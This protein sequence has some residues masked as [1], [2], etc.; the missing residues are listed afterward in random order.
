MYRCQIGIGC[1]QA[2]P[3][4]WYFPISIFPID[5]SSRHMF[6]SCLLVGIVI[7]HTIFLLCKFLCT[8]SQNTLISNFSMG[9]HFYPPISFICGQITNLLLSCRHTRKQVAIF[10]VKLWLKL[11]M[12]LWCFYRHIKFWNLSVT[13]P[14]IKFCNF[15]D[16]NTNRYFDTHVKPQNSFSY[17]KF[18]VGF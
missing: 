15:G 7:S 11:Q 3:T 18:W 5:L 9:L 13:I 16:R 1:P 6:S 14:V 2:T 8:V 17:E 12:G 10:R 4:L